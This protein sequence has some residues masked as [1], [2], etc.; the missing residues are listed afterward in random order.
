MSFSIIIQFLYIWI[1]LIFFKFSEEE[2]ESPPEEFDDRPLKKSRLN[3]VQQRI[4][5][6]TSEISSTSKT[7]QNSIFSSFLLFL[8]LQIRLLPNL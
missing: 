2:E 7:S 3:M 8:F 4:R 1:L 5:D 6:L